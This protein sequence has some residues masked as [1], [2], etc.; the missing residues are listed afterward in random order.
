M[1]TQSVNDNIRGVSL[2]V[3]ETSQSAGEVE[4]VAKAASAEAQQ[5]KRLVQQFLQDVKVA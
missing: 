4:G 2:S 5:I 1:A 3:S